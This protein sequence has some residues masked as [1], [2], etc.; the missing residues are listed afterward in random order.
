M[1]PTPS[2]LT[3]SAPGQRFSSSASAP[4]QNHMKRDSQP[5]L[6]SS[7]RG[8]TADSGGGGSA[9]PDAADC[10][11]SD[12]CMG[13]PLAADHTCRAPKSAGGQTSM[14]VQPLV[15]CAKSSPSSAMFT[16]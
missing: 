3:R 1:P 14:A 2:Y 10:S 11:A 15:W 5:G 7:S 6:G 16:P 9:A 12:V 8:G 13:G 4:A